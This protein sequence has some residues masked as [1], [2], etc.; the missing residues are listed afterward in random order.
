MQQTYITIWHQRL[1]Y[2]DQYSDTEGLK[3]LENAQ[4][5]V[6]QISEENLK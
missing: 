1:V 2:I 6:L 3:F 5:E 4:V